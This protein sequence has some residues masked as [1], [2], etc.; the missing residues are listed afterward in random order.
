[1]ENIDRVITLLKKNNE[2]LTVIDISRILKISRNTVS[3]V[4]AGLIGAGKVRVRPV[5]VAK[6]HYWLSSGGGK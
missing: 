6:L 2:G 5:G 4:L 1:M 3:V